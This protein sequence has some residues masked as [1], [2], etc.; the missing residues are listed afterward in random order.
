MLLKGCHFKVALSVCCCLEETQLTWNSFWLASGNDRIKETRFT[1]PLQIT[2]KIDKIYETMVLR[3]CTMHSRGKWLLRDKNKWGV[4]NEC[5][6]LL[7][8]S[9][10]TR[11]KGKD[12]QS[13]VSYLSEF[14]VQGGKNTDFRETYHRRVL[15]RNMEM[16]GVFP[17]I[18][19]ELEISGRKLMKNLQMLNNSWVKGEIDS[20]IKLEKT[21]VLTILNLPIHKYELS[22]HL[23]RYLTSSIRVCSFFS[24]IDPAHSLLYL[25]LKYFTFLVLMQK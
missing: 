13:V 8:G 5:L 1:L 21:D 6:W 7:S 22:P 18:T 12:I 16:H 9:F 15:H 24:H 2:R 14:K 3:H 11:V 19:T 23:V 10:Q 20:K 17:L 25:Y 4:P